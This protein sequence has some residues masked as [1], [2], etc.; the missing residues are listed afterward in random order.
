MHACVEVLRWLTERWMGKLHWKYHLKQPK[1]ILLNRNILTIQY[2]THLT[3]S[4][5]HSKLPS[6]LDSV[7][8]NMLSWE[9]SFWKKSRCKKHPFEV[10]K[11]NIQRNLVNL[12]CVLARLK[13]KV[14]YIDNHLSMCTE[15]PNPFHTP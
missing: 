10:V 2:K 7:E 11:L 1:T 3:Y 6:Y 12:F 5:N 14:C 4:V 13:V 8:I 9:S 15:I